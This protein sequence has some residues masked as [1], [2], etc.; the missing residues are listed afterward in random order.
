MIHGGWKA[1]FKL[2]NNQAAEQLLGLKLL[3]VLEH[4]TLGFQ[5][6]LA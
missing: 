4:E 1:P 6:L 3:D 2:Q 5:L